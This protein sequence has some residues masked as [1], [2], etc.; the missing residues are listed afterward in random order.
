MKA[1][2]KENIFQKLASNIWSVSTNPFCFR[3]ALTTANHHQ[4]RRIRHSWHVGME[5]ALDFLDGQ[6]SGKDKKIT[7]FD[8]IIGFGLLEQIKLMKDAGARIAVDF[9]IFI[10]MNV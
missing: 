8:A 3:H 5:S 7:S 6:L 1:R 4:D 9:N 2:N 10:R